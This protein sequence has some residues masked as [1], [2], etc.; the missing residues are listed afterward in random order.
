MT[1]LNGML[2]LS[3]RA[4]SAQQLALAVIGH[5]TANVNTPGFSRQRVQ[6]S[7]SWAFQ[8]AQGALGTGVNVVGIQQIHDYL[9]DRNLRQSYSDFSQWEAID[10]SLQSLE[11]IFG[12]TSTSTNLEDLLTQFWNSWQDLAND[13]ENLTARSSLRENAQSLCSE[14]NRLHTQFASQRQSHDQEIVVRVNEVN[15]KASAI[16]DLNARIAQIESSGGMANDLRD[17]RTTLL[18]D[19]SSLVNLQVTDQQ[20]GQI[21]VYVGGQILVQGD[22]SQQIATQER[23]VPGGVVHDLVWQ[24]GGSAV[25]LSQGQIAGL[26]EMRDERIPEVSA[27]LDELVNTLVEQVNTA[28]AAGYGLNGSSGNDFFDPET[29]GAGDI[30]L[31]GAVLSSLEVIAASGSGAPGDNSTALAIAGLQNELLMEDGTATIGNYYA[32]LVSEIGVGRQNAT[33]RHTQEQAALDQLET[34]RE[35][36]SGVSLDEEMTNMIQYQQAYEAAARMV[37]TVS[38]L[39]DTVINLV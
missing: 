39:M 16:A 11:N 13:P 29:T 6:L 23:S 38:Q 32:N 9:L 34:Q 22:M 20:N 33:F 3:R 4:L 25:I 28:H 27:S 21:N 17:Q 12:D 31:S 14:F 15:T 26:I 8:M 30:S 19:L 2:D 36:I 10:N 18:N 35:S 24:D 5:N 1:T 37:A 7:P